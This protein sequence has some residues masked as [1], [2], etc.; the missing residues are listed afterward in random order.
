MR[1]RAIWLAALAIWEV[2]TCLVQ[3][4]LKFNHQQFGVK[5]VAPCQRG[6]DET[7][8]LFNDRYGGRLY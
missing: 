8:S 2:F 5:R 3:Q 1:L 7:H 4:T 6:G